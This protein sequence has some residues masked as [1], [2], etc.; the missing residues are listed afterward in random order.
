MATEPNTQ[1]TSR[2]PR[3]AWL[4]VCAAVLLLAACGGG[5]GPSAEPAAAEPMLPTATVDDRRFVLW[6]PGT[7]SAVRAEQAA[8]ADGNGGDEVRLVVRMNPASVP[9]DNRAHMAGAAGTGWRSR[10]PSQRPRA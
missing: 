2:G 3:A 9:A 1:S 10:A 5:S 4:P 8:L 7:E 6:L